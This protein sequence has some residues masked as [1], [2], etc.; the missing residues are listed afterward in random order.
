MLLNV[1]NSIDLSKQSVL[2]GFESH[3]LMSQRV[4]CGTEGYRYKGTLF[5]LEMIIKLTDAKELVELAKSL[6]LQGNK[7]ALK[8]LFYIEDTDGKT[9]RDHFFEKLEGKGVTV[10]EEGNL[11][12][13][14]KLD[15]HDKA[16]IAILN[17]Q[18]ARNV[19]DNR[20]RAF[21]AGGQSIYAA[22]YIV[23][24]GASELKRLYDGAALD[25][26]ALISALESYLDQL[27]VTAGFTSE[28]KASVKRFLAN[29]KE[30]SKYTGSPF[31]NNKEMLAYIWHGISDRDQR[32]F[33]LGAET[34]GTESEQWDREIASHRLEF[35]KECARSQNEYG[36]DSPLDVSMVSLML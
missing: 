6:S 32:R 7:R 20:I 5:H 10:D 29:F 31:A 27:E 23:D 36:A 4:D 17:G 19:D 24:K 34:L 21:L 15:D 13:V 30:A 12:N 22:S 11:Q 9:V 18:E 35:F 1:L 33:R 2:R 16:F 8:E 28:N 14:D 3:A 25:I 26:E